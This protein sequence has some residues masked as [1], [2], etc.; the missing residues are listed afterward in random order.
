MVIRKNNQKVKKKLL[1][2]QMTDIKTHEYLNI[3]NLADILNQHPR[4]HTNL[5]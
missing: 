5:L 1:T 4:I 3:A 2:F